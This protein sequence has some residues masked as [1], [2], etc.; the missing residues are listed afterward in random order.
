M[1]AFGQQQFQDFEPE[2][3]QFAFYSDNLYALYASTVASELLAGDL[4]RKCQMLV[5]PSFSAEHAVYLIRSENDRTAKVVLREFEKHWWP[6]FQGAIAK[7]SKDS[8]PQVIAKVSKPTRRL[9]APITKGT[10]DRLEEV[11]AEMLSRVRYRPET[12][13]GLDGTT[14]HAA[15]FEIN[16]GYR[17]GRTWSPD[18][19]TFAFDLVDLAATLASL[20]RSPASERLRIEAALMQRADSLLARLRSS[21]R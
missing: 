10:A 18:K 16:V 12:R 9:E 3:G 19:G 5:T 11:W 20:P 7:A 2:D 17:A 14:Y 21:G 4:V 1:A 13:M 15:H 8:I 6:E